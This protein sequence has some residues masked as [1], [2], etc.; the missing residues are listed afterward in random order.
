MNSISSHPGFICACA[1]FASRPDLLCSVIAVS[2]RA[3]C[4]FQ[5]AAAAAA[6]DTPAGQQLLEASEDLQGHFNQLLQH[7]SAAAAAAAAAAQHS[8]TEQQQQHSQLLELVR[9][10]QHAAM[11]LYGW[12]S[13]LVQQAAVP[14]TAS[15]AGQQLALIPAVEIVPK[16]GVVALFVYNLR[17]CFARVQLAQISAAGSG[18]TTSPLSRKHVVAVLLLLLLLLL[19]CTCAA[20]LLLR[21]VSAAFVAAFVAAVGA[22]HCTLCVSAVACAAWYSVTVAIAYHVCRLLCS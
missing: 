17:L 20:V 4:L 18:C 13:K 6:A 2:C 1:F 19:Y 14:V 11:Q 12:A 7:S 16:V 5:P 8:A 10:I 15:E 3:G 9:S 22:T 21:H